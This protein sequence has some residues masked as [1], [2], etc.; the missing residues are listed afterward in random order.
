MRA[1]GLIGKPLIS[2]T[3][4][5][6]VSEGPNTLLERR[7]ASPAGAGH[8]HLADPYP[9][10]MRIT[11]A[12]HEVARSTRALVLKEVGKSLYNPTFYV[13]AADVDLELFER[14]VGYT[15]HCPIK[16]DASYWRFRGSGDGI[17]RAAWSYDAPVDYSEMIAGHF[18]FDQRFAT[19]EISPVS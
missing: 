1:R 11:I 12:G 14:E 7:K 16:G 10:E 6:H 4:R 2:H 15:T 13:P 17:E 19:I 18:G 3:R 5:A 9:Y 8:Y